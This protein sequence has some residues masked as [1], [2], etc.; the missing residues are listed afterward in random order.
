MEPKQK[1][2]YEKPIL[3]KIR[4]DAECAVLGFYKTGGKVGP[5]VGSGAGC[6]PGSIWSSIGS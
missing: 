1:K 6:T 4:L 5:G 3:T 2:K